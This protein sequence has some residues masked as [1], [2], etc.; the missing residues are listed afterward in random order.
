MIHN[1]VA[2]PALFALV[3]CGGGGA[4][5]KPSPTNPGARPPVP[6]ADAVNRVDLV[7]QGGVFVTPEKLGIGIDPPVGKLETF[8]D[9]LRLSVADPAVAAGKRADRWGFWLFADGKIAEDA[10]LSCRTGTQL[11]IDGIAYAPAALAKVPPGPTRHPLDATLVITRFEP[12]RGLLEAEI[13]GTFLTPDGKTGIKVT[14]TMRLPWPQP[15]ADP[16]P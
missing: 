15:A 11:V 6:A 2:I 1:L 4:E 3:S 10:S 9:G 7:L 12:E 14:G 8:A 13:H 5:G 16:D